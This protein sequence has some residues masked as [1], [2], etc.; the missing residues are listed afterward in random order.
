[1]LRLTVY[2]LAKWMLRHSKIQPETGVLL[3][4]RSTAVKSAWFVS[5]PDRCRATV[6]SIANA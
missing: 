1:M 2:V 3:E 5:V 6:H 4:E